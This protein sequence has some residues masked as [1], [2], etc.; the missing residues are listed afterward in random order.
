[1]RLMGY[2]YSPL[3][4]EIRGQHLIILNKYL[5]ERKMKLENIKDDLK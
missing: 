4:H 1:M 3:Y 5:I 2:D